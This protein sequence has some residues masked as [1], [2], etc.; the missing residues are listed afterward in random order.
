MNNGGRHLTETGRRKT[1]AHY[2]KVAKSYDTLMEKAGYNS[3]I[4]RFV[5]SLADDVS[6]NAR[7]LDLG[8]GTGFATE[9][10]TDRLPDAE[11]CGLDHSI[12]MLK[13]CKRRIPSIQL[14][15]GDF[16]DKSTIC[17]MDDGKP[18]KLNDNSFD[19]IISTGA[20]SEYGDLEKVIPLVQSLLVC[21]GTFVNVGLKKNIVNTISGMVWHFRPKSIGSVMNSCV[22]YGFRTVQ[23]V[24]IPWKLFPT[25]Y[26]KYA[27]RAKK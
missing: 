5:S 16:N 22:R 6:G 25:S 7:I 4:R 26:L 8:C 21:G 3:T 14:M 20:V 24:P 10:L 1:A 17:S 18:V 27:I 12:E 2:D 15:V 11:I 19:F 13:I 23:R 9:V